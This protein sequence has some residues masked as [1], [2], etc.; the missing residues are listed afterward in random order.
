MSSPLS[1]SQPCPGFMLELIQVSSAVLT[2]P[3]QLTICG[4]QPPVGPQTTIQILYAHEAPSEDLATPLCA[5]SDT[6]VGITLQNLTQGQASVAGG[7]VVLQGDGDQEDTDNLVPLNW[8]DS[9]GC[10]HFEL[11]SE[12][13]GL[14]GRLAYP[15]SQTLNLGSRV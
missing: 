6:V 11:N 8:R 9:M 7:D 2:R 3:V 13:V 15:K 12:K 1:F 14:H 10:F 5:G 4:T